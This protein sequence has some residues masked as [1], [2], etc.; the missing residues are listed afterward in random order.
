LVTAPRPTNI[1]PET[2]K[3]PGAHA[4]LI[5]QIAEADALI[6]GPTQ[7]MIQAGKNLKWVQILSAEVRPYLYPEM[8]G[9]DLVMTNLRGV[10]APGVADHGVAM[11][12]ALTRQLTRFIGNRNLERFE[13]E[14]FGVLELKG[15]TAIVIGVG[16]IGLNVAQR[17]HG[18]EVN[19]IGVDVEDIPVTQ[20]TSRV[21][22]PDRLDEF[23]PRANM[24]FMCAPSTPLTD[25]MMGAKQFRLLPP[26]SY[27]IAVSRGSTY[28][29]TALVDALETGRL[30][31]AAVDVTVPEPLP[32]GHPLWHYDN[33]IIT[34]HCATESQMEMP[35]RLALVK[36]NLT[37]FSAGRRLL[38]IVDKQKGY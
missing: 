33:V 9:G 25:G 24:V 15:M 26:G 27:F 37:R 38:N 29:M 18:F 4:A 19:V 12:L 30:A 11:L 20:W 5:R 34:Y 36:E 10:A 13:R 35:R 3:T 14:R 31:G 32:S 6:G 17:L 28:D 21:V 8:V 22:T 7:E 16:N 23:L 2:A 1:C